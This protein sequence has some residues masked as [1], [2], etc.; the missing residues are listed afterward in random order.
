MEAKVPKR[1]LCRKSRV[2]PVLTPLE[3]KTPSG[4]APRSW[5]DEE[6]CTL[7]CWGG[8][9]GPHDFGP[10]E[11]YVRWAVPRINVNA[12]HYLELE[13]IRGSHDLNERMIRAGDIQAFVRDFNEKRQLG[14]PMLKVVGENPPTIEISNAD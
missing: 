4:I 13:G 12:L 11:R 5:T 9:K 3:E 14:T 6:G 10:G 1:I 2:E 8:H 7:I